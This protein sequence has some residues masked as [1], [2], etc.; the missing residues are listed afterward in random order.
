M[1]GF[2]SA[3][4]STTPPVCSASD[5]AIGVPVPSGP[6]TWPP[7]RVK[8]AGSPPPAAAASTRSRTSSAAFWIAEPA[9]PV[10]IE[11]PDIG[12]DGSELSPSCTRTISLGT[13]STS[14]AT[15]PSTV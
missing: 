9:D 7:A 14:A 13:P 12:P 2:Q 3:V 11:P 6:I 15:W 5:L 10:V 8:P 1:S 4:S